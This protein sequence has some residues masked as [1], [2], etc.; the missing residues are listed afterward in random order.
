MASPLRYWLA[1]AALMAF[2]ALAPLSAQTAKAPAKPKAPLTINVIDVAGDLQI[3]QPALE[4]FQKEH[5]DLV[6]RFVFTKATAPE[7][8]GKLRAQQD[9]GRVDID[10]VLTGNDALAAGMEQNIWL[11]ILPKY[12]DRFPALDKLYLPG[13]YAMQKM[14]QGQAF[15][16]DWYPSGPLL[17]YD[18]QQLKAVPDT[19]ESLLAWCKA[20]PNRFMYARPAN[21]GPGR[22]FVMGLPYLLGDKDPQDPIHGWDKTWAYLKEMNTCIEYYPSGTTATMKELAEGS[23]D[24]IATTTGW[25]IN[26]R[27]L[28]IVPEQFKV[29]TLKGFHWVGDA[30]YMAI[31]KGVAPEKLDVV[32]ALMAYLLEPAQ[33]AYM[34]DHGYMYPGPAIHGVTIDMAPKESQQ[35]IAKFGRQ[36]Y[37]AMISDNPTEPP[38]DSK[39]LVAMFDKWDRE[40]GN[41]KTKK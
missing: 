23:R 31:P 7:L 30:N 22:T 15:V 26:P 25:D 11:E 33:Q 2:G 4:K 28:G 18:P 36:E 6:S 20:H 27:Y 16:L 34:Y 39:P 13:A 14:A 40:I 35:T 21:S 29:A 5:P 9:A 32:L 3:S 8:A 37:A 17:E 41:S 38:L 24:I 10:F 12:A 19:A 1:T